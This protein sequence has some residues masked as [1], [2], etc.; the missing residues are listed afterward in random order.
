VPDEPHPRHV[1]AMALL[2]S[3]LHD[4]APPSAI[5][6]ALAGF[7]PAYEDL[8]Q[9][10]W[11]LRSFAL[12]LAEGDLAAPLEMRGRV[13]GALKALQ[14]NLRHLTWQTQAVAA[15]DLTQHVMF[16]GEFSAAFNTMVDRLKE[17]QD[18]L[19]EEAIRDPLTGLLNRRYLMET[20]PR[21]LARANREGRPVA[22]MMVDVDHF[23]DVNDTRGHEGGDHVLRALGD[24][25]RRMTRA[26]DVACRWGGE[27]FVVLLPGTSIE[28][29]TRRADEM[30][31]AFEAQS[32]HVGGRP[33]RC[34]VSVGISGF[35]VH[36]SM[37]DAL[38]AAA[39]GAMYAA[40]AAGRNRVHAARVGQEAQ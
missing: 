7:A 16:L 15:G 6:P 19:R 13:P 5:P 18:Q 24:L 4:A 39:D 23:K 26:S 11:A 9:G 20:M 14:A 12:A 38:L 33:I 28:I 2:Q 31:A 34:T 1:E 37:P 36:G 29:A 32:V 22:V 25:L 17:L 27:E 10:L 21:E 40:K 3:V 8:F 30:R 35:P